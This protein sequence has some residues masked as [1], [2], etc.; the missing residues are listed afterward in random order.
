MKAKQRISAPW[1]LKQRMNQGERGWWLRIG[2]QLIR[3]EYE[4]GLELTYWSVSFGSLLLHRIAIRGCHEQK[5][6]NEA[7]AWL[8]EQAETV[9]RLAGRKA[10]SDLG[11]SAS[12]PDS[13]AMCAVNIRY[14]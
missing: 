3:V 6:A 13:G 7:G 4:R 8:V 9:L 11:A 5:A 10:V 1:L 12:V 14:R 2:E